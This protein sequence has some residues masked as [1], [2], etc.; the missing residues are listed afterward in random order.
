MFSVKTLTLLFQLKKKSYIHEIL[1]LFENVL[2]TQGIIYKEE[3]FKVEQPLVNFQKKNLIY[4][5]HKSCPLKVGCNKS[6]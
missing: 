1:N 2:A 4:L 3:Q 5:S 6:Y